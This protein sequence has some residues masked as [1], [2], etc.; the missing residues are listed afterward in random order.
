M[1]L[2]KRSRAFSKFDCVFLESPLPRSDKPLHRGV[3][4]GF[5]DADRGTLMNNHRRFGSLDRKRMAFAPA[6]L[7]A[8]LFASPAF[9]VP[10]YTVDLGVFVN[11]QG[12][13]EGSTSGE[14]SSNSV[15]VSQL[16]QLPGATGFG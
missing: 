5:K 1:S 11:S 8:L 10:S 4:K 7:R 12:V 16:Y 13:F 3:T 15:S 14:T 2:A 9:A 6:F